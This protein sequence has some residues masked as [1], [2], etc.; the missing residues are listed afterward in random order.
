MITSNKTVIFN[1][2]LERDC[3]I[4]WFIT[5]IWLLCFS[6]YKDRENNII[7]MDGKEQLIGGCGAMAFTLVSINLGICQWHYMLV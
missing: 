1:K 3:C 6:N 5:A 4:K 7:R 2:I